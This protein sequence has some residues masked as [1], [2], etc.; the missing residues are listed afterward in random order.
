MTKSQA[1]RPKVDLDVTRERLVR[2][3]LG[4]AAE[5]A[6]EHITAAVKDSVSPHRFLDQLL[7]V[8]L[9]RR[10]ERRIKTAL[11]LSGL[12]TGQTL[13]NFDFSFQPSIERSRIE[14]LGT[15]WI[16][17]CSR[18]CSPLSSATPICRPA[19]CDAAS[20]TTSPWSSST[21]S[22]SSR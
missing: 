20:T 9:T 5:L 6:E 18:S 1:P 22:V 3:G 11:K 8:E 15:A 17:D 16:R 13:G 7:D 4:H 2:L 14:T 10:E 21:R 19:A 12:P